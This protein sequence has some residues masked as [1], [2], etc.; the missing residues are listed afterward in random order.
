MK[1]ILTAMI[2]SGFALAAYA[3][4]ETGLENGRHLGWEKN[5]TLTCDAPPAKDCKIHSVPDGGNTLGLLAVGMAALG[6]W[7]TREFLKA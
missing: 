3:T 6:F 7:K 4:S 5:G 1:L 2:A